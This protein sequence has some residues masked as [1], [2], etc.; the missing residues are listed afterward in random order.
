MKLKVLIFLIFIFSFKLSSAI[1]FDEIK[2]VKGIPFWFVQDSSLPLISMSFS[3]RGGAFLDPAGKEGSTNLMVSLLDEGTENFNGNKYKLSLKEN[4]TKISFSADKDKIEGTFQVVSTQI[5][6]GFWLLF[7]SINNP[8]FNSEEIEKVKKQVQASI[9]ID[10]SD[11]QSQASDRFNQNFFQNSKL[12]RNVKGNLESLKKITRKDIFKMHKINFT[13]D[14]LVI[15]LAGDIDA[16]A[17]S[18]YID[19]VFGN[20]PLLGET[21]EIPKLGILKKGQ[22]SYE[23]ETPQSTVIFGQRGVSR[24]DK[25]YFSVRV[26]NYILGGGGFQSRL[27]KEV[28]EKSGL[29]YSIYSYLIPYQNDGVI[30]GGFQTRNETV[31]ETISKVK[32]Q[33]EKI[34]KNGISARELRDAQTYY[35]GSFS[36]NF[37]STLSLASLLKVV[38]YYDLGNDYFKKRSEIIDNL[39]INDINTLASKL[40][41]KNNLFFMIVGKTDT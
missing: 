30:I 33:W 6:E 14:N 38:Q 26:L 22:I 29:V 28:R 31:N 32:E 16:E 39:K 17:A 2:S 41:D 8:L 20:L 4:G 11:V 12:S 5:Q 40:F 35:K 3:F 18:K 34:K 36:R 27:Y 37:T 10:K 15:G 21:R 19:Y 24:K 1:E 7:E 23:M 13:R 25:D 9:K